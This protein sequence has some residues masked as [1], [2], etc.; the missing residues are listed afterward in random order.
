MVSEKCKDCTPD[1]VVS[2]RATL[3]KPGEKNGTVEVWVNH[4][5]VSEGGSVRACRARVC[6]CVS[7]RK[8][9]KN[10]RAPRWCDGA[11]KKG[12]ASP[13]SLLTIV[14]FVSQ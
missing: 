3:T 6:V 8:L 1:G 2:W 14:F 7:H 9:T 13:E 11:Y 5:K 10:R 12:G 4:T